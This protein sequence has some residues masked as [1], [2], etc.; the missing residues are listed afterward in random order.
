MERT[1]VAHTLQQSL[2]PPTL[3]RIPGA[4]V[5]VR[6]HAAGRGVEVGGDFYDAFETA[7]GYALVIGDVCGKGPGAA[8]V[9][10]L[11]RY[12]I[13]AVAMFESRPDKILTRLNEALLR[14]SESGDFCTALVMHVKPAASGHILQVA[15]AGHPL[16]LLL[17][18]DGSGGEFGRPGTMLG[19]IPDA[20]LPVDE[21][22]LRPGDAC[23][24]YT[25][26]L[27]EAAAP[28][29]LTPENL[30]TLLRTSAAAGAEA[31]ARRL[32]VIPTSAGEQMRDDTAIV[33]FSVDS[34]GS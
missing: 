2:L 8:A 27:N 30:I 20:D 33:V 16:P 19:V 22:L 13:R 34:P 25:D 18:P 5:A 32:D 10:A 11:A 3:A 26:G 1:K 28:R 9:T 6:F 12:T 31:V 24:V 15:S 29:I 23:I 21:V 17:R 14:Q 7:G 4:Q